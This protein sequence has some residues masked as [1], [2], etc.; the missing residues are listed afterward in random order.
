MAEITP[1]ADEDYKARDLGAL[2]LEIVENRAK[3][4][5]DFCDVHGYVDSVTD[6]GEVE[7]IAPASQEG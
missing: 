4:E 5:A 3:G 7:K 2:K 1:K 6:V